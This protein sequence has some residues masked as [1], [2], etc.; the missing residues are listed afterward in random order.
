MRLLRQ[1]SLFALAALAGLGLAAC[2]GGGTTVSLTSIS[3]APA[4][5]T[6]NVGGPTTQLTVTGYYSDGRTTNLTSASTFVSSNTSVISV[7]ASGVVTPVAVGTAVVTATN[8]GSGK[9]AATEL[10]TV[11]APL[12]PVLQSIAV[13]A[14]A[15]ALMVGGTT[16]LTVTGTYDKGPTQN[17]TA[18][19]TFVA[20]TAGVVSIDSA[21]LVTAVAAGT[22]TIT[23]TDTASGKTATS[24]TITVT[25]TPPPTLQSI[26]VTAASSS[27]TVGGA[28]TQLTVLGTYSNSTTKDLTSASTFVAN[29]A[30]VVSISAAGVVTPVAAGTTTITATNTASGKTATT[31][32]ITVT[33]AGVPVTL[34]SIA[35]TAASNSLTI[36]GATTQLTVLGTYSDASTKNLTSG[37]TFVANTAGVVSISAA[38]VVT[39][40][41]AGT[42]TITATNTASGKT[43]TSAVITVSAGAA[44]YTIL[45]FN[46]GTLTYNFDSFSTGAIVSLTSTGVPPSAPAGG[47]AF[48][49]FIRHGANPGPADQ[50]YSGATM[51]AQSATNGYSESIGTIPLSNTNSVVTGVVYVPVAGV[52]YRLKLEDAS[53]VNHYVEI[54][55]VPPTTGW[56]TLTWDAKKFASAPFDPTFTFNKLTLFPD[57]SCASGAPTPPNDE[58]LY[59][60]QFTFLGASGPSAPALPFPPPP[61]APSATAATP[62]HP[63]GNVL[64]LYNSSG[65]YTDQAGTNYNPF[66]DSKTVSQYSIGSAKVWE[67]AV[68]NYQGWQFTTIDISSY[69][70]MHVDVWTPDT[71]QFGVILVN[72]P[73]GQTQGQ[74]NFNATTTPAITKSGWISLDIP[75]SSFTAGGLGATT[76]I[77]QLLFVDNVGGNNNGTFFIDNVYF[78]K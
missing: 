34:Q 42:T 30:G 73:T 71:T 2:D 13:T 57:F 1:F 20:N 65:T 47:P 46:D 17:L 49:K 10:I 54:D 33:A 6:L 29:T 27:L 75:V 77:Y 67:Y 24:A 19:S 16:Q 18:G 66:G 63:A 39:P 21:G 50:C 44:S 36:G 53:N 31:T 8:A 78:W 61:P 58:T 38:G 14:A 74:V 56:Q 45:G 5:S 3:V 60:A 7:D 23:A 11:D 22:T 51:W 37:S 69:T 55:V 40:V 64:S 59:V 43:A 48:V 32:A 26:A 70:T 9:T 68:M 52:T 28:T 12:P 72:G 62:T 76:S 4:S 25:M 35:V 41:A 15:D